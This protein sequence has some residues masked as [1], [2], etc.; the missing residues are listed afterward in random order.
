MHTLRSSYAAKYRFPPED[1]DFVFIFHWMRWN[2][3]GDLSAAIP[4]LRC[5][6]RTGL[7]CVGKIVAWI[8]HSAGLVA[9]L[10]DVV[11]Y[12]WC[13]T[14]VAMLTDCFGT[15][16]ARRWVNWR[17][18][19][20]WAALFIYLKTWDVLAIC[21]RGAVNMIEL[22]ISPKSVSLH[23]MKPWFMYSIDARMFPR[24]SRPG[25]IEYIGKY[26]V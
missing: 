1:A 7:D 12:K 14:V 17:N 8:N 22:C 26:K 21:P 6:L 13:R 24:S 2:R 15:R 9:P 5:N 4:S 23:H 20:F 10:F 16:N 11:C 25:G 3:Q 18:T 19:W